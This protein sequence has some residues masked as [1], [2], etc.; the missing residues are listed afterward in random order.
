MVIS[1]S[2]V[3][4]HAWHAHCPHPTVPHATPR[5][6]TSTCITIDAY[7]H[8]H[9]STTHRI[10]IIVVS[11]AHHPAKHAH[12]YQLIHAYHALPHTISSIAHAYPRVPAPTT[13][14]ST[15][16]LHVYLRVWIVY[17]SC[18]VA[19][20]WLASTSMVVIVLVHATLAWLSSM[21]ISV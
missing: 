1:V 10:A 14:M 12:P 2:H 3:L 11:C 21:A 15:N 4:F 5:L 18:S 20:A 19:V 7:R 8:A 13:T 17:L 16:A 9:P 6:P